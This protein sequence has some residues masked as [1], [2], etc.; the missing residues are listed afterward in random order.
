M[1]MACVAWPTSPVGLYRASF[2]VLQ[3]DVA[4]AHLHKAKEGVCMQHVACARSKT[5]LTHASYIP[6]SREPE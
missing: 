4:S 1:L 3:N 2:V 5:L 6:V